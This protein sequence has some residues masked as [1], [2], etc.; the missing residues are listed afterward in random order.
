MNKHKIKLGDLVTITAKSYRDNEGMYTMHKFKKDSVCKVAYIA[1]PMRASNAIRPFSWFDP[2]RVTIHV[3]GK[4]LAEVHVSYNEVK[5]LSKDR[6]IIPAIDTS[7]FI[8]L[9][10]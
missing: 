1:Y 3:V 10:T 6:S 7:D 5:L 8:S 4:P 9:N 2:G